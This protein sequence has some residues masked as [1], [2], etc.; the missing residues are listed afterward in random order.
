MPEWSLREEIINAFHNWPVIVASILGGALLGLLVAFLIPAP[1]R[2]ST[3]IAVLINPYRTVEDRYNA[4]YT[5]FEF[6]NPDDYK[7]WQMSQ[8]NTLVYSDE[9]IE[10]TLRRLRTQD[11][12]WNDVSHADLSNMLTVA[13]RNAGRWMLSAE[14]D[15][16]QMAAEALEA[17]KSV[18]LEK[19]NASIDQSKKLYQIDLDLRAIT[20]A[21]LKNQEQQLSL[22]ASL[23]TIKEMSEELGQDSSDQPLDP[24]VRSRLLQSVAQSAELN[25]GW[26]TVFETFPVEGAPTSEYQNWIDLAIAALEQGI[27]TNTQ[28]SALLDRDRLDKTAEWQAGLEAGKGLAATLQVEELAKKAPKIQQILSTSLAMLVGALLGLIVWLFVILIRITRKT[29]LHRKLQ[30]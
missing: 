3:D 23:E 7:H 12:A 14:T 4:A 27:Q 25:A 19:V 18:I 29:D 21:Q 30:V 2:A 16:Q 26:R 13:W 11:Q 1:Y 28:Q 8:L 15:N 20:T 22:E 6:R 10:E 24:V 5:N 17:W 9:Y